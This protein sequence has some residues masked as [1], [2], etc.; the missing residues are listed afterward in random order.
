MHFVLKYKKKISNSK[1]V[2][3]VIAT[4]IIDSEYTEPV[5][6]CLKREHKIKNRFLNVFFKVSILVKQRNCNK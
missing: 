6:E 5:Q 4:I 1:S 2:P 3:Y